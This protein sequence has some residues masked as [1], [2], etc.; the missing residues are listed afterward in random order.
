MNGILTVDKPKGIT[1]FGVIA[2]LRRILN[3]KKIGHC[4]TLDPM[5]TG[6]MTV[7]CGNCTRFCLLLPDT[8][9]E[10]IASFSLGIETDTLDIT[11]R[12]IS[13]KKVNV[14]TLDV[15]NAL[16]NF[17]G[18]IVQVPPM[19]SAVSVGGERLYELA[20]KGIEIE[21][22]PRIVNIYNTDLLAG[23]ENSNEYKIRVACS[24]GTYIRSLISDL[25]NSL[26][27]GAVLTSLRRTKA[28]GFDITDCNSLET[29]KDAA[30][31]GI[32]SEYLLPIDQALKDYP[33]IIVT[34]NQSVRFKNGGEL[35]TE[36][37]SMTLDRGYC[38]VYNRTGVFLGIGEFDGSDTMKVK[39]V[40]KSD[41][42]F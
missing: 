25:G 34:D 36:R 23:D 33:E 42:Q 13:E 41:E 3:E 21:R 14:K 5:A 30:E 8:D 31:K 10:Y 7:L 38:R 2:K 28:N 4:G 40:Y 39:R 20:R 18:E 6:V 19:Y 11:G 24:S 32:V 16:N 15:E 27:C 9:K 12:V 29:L 35:F 26:G 1:S 22:K 17:T 37:L